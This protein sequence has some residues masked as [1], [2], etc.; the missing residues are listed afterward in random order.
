MQTCIN[1]PRT[2]TEL[3]AY[4]VKR[5]S[6]RTFQVIRCTLCR[7]RSE[8]SLNVGIFMNSGFDSGGVAIPMIR[9]SSACTI[10]LFLHSF[11]K[12]REWERGKKW[13]KDSSKFTADGIEKRPRGGLSA[14]F[15]ILSIP[16]SCTGQFS[17]K[18]L[19]G[20]WSA[21]E[22]FGRHGTNVSYIK[23]GGHG[24]GK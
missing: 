23:A 20:R 10:P 5:R 24:Q 4:Y 15:R 7:S 19:F 11:Y 21:F 17:I 16:V 6:E 12:D 3:C 8:C 13:P 18:M 22:G 14:V 2:L 1:S 9:R